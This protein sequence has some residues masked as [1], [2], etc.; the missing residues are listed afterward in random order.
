M[1][2]TPRQGTIGGGVWNDDFRKPS[3]YSSKDGSNI[4]AD[5]VCHTK[6]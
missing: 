5:K 6:F 4:A 2:E 3:V 1:T